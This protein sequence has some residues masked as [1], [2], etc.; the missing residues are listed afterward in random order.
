MAEKLPGEE[1]SL[2]SLVRFFI[3]ILAPERS[4]YAL[5]IIYGQMRLRSDS[6]WEDDRY[7]P[8]QYS[9][10]HRFDSVNFPDMEYKDVFGGTMGEKEQKE[11]DYH[12]IG[13]LSGKSKAMVE[14]ELKSTN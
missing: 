5:A 2:S 11:M 8:N 4:Y 1:N 12:K 10:P 14:Q 13:L 6:V 7:S 9:H 3:D